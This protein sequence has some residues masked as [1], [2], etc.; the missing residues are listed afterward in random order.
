VGADLGAVAVLERGDDPAAVGVVLGV[1]RGDD[2]DVE[3]QAD[4]VAADLT[5]RS[6]MMLRQADLDPLGEVRQ[7]VEAED[8]AVGPRDQP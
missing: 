7:L 5:S 4:L 1:G 6:S 3:R 2:E 8:A